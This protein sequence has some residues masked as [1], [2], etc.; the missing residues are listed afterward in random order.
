MVAILLPI[1]VPDLQ[2]ALEGY[3]VIRVQR[4][5]TG[6]SGSYTELTRAPPS[7]SA[8]L[9]GSEE[10]PF[11]V[12]TLTLEF[13]LDS[14]SNQVVTFAGTNPLS[15][16]NVAAQT[17]NQTGVE[18]AENDDNRLRLTSRAEGTGSRVAITGGTALAVLGF[19]L[20]QLDLG[21]SPWIVMNAQTRDYPF[22][23]AA[24]DDSFYYRTFFFNTITGA[25]S[26]FSAPV[27]GS[28]VV[29]LASD[30]LSLATVDLVDA[31]GVGMPGRKISIFPLPVG[32][33]RGDFAVDLWKKEE[34][35][36][37]NDGHAELTLIRGIRVKVLFEGTGFVRELEV[38]NAST[39]NLVEAAGAAP[40]AFTVT[41]PNLPSA[42]RRSS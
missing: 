38:P 25:T 5:T 42:V 24:G 19:T 18:T 20:N 31:R 12:D 1:R 30:E 9:L 33:L 2:S 23:D 16:G 4:A 28:P 14:G 15:I 7:D 40:D 22:V 17:N 41:F 27:R 34:I 11:A 3:D 21:A 32:A 13:I 39:F 6:P 10:G 8:T 37:D 26:D 29:L 35:E 36:T